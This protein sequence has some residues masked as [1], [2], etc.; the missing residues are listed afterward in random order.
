LKGRG[1]ALATVE[2]VKL[3]AECP[4]KAIGDVGCTFTVVVGDNIVIDNTVDGQIGV[5]RALFC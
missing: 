1:G 4:V 3:R 2:E 5:E